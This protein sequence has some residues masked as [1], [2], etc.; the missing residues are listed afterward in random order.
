[1][2]DIADIMSDSD[3]D[4]SDDSG[5]PFDV[6]IEKCEKRL[7][8]ARY[9]KKYRNEWD[10]ITNRWQEKHIHIV[11]K[12]IEQK[13]RVYSAGSHGSIDFTDVSDAFRYLED[14]LW[15]HY[16]K[17]EI[18]EVVMLEFKC[19]YNS[20]YFPGSSFHFSSLRY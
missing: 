2:A 6:E 10:Y 19:D 18:E 4:D 5:L 3:S 8:L 20:R 1:M 9:K 17:Q 11:L 7:Q 12:D 14:V 15:L 16:D 13:W